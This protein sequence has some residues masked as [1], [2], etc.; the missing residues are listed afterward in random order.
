MQQL[1]TVAQNQSQMAKTAQL[2]DFDEVL[3]TQTSSVF[4]GS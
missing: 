1:L 2:S 4:H 3:A